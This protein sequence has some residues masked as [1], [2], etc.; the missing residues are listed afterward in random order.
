T[1][2]KVFVAQYLSLHHNNPNDPNDQV[3]LAAGSVFMAVTITDGDGDTASAGGNDISQQVGFKD[4]GP[5]ITAATNTGA[6]VAHDETPGVQ[7][8]DANGT[9]TAYGAAT[10][11]SLFTAVPSPGDDPDVTG[12]GPIGYA[13]STAS[14]VTV[15]NANYGADGQGAAPLSYALSVTD[16]TDS[17]VA[18]TAGTEIYLYNG[19]GGLVLGRVGTWS[20]ADPNGTTAFALADDPT[21]GKVFVAQ[22]LS[23]HHPNAADPNDQVNLAAGSVFMA[24][25]ITDGDGDTASAGGNDISLQVG[26]KDDGPAIT[27]ATNTGASVVHDETPGVQA[28]DANGTDTAYGAATIASLFTAV[29]SPGDDPDVTGSGPIGYAAS[30][31]SLVTVTNANYG[32]DG[33]GAAPLSYALSVTDGT[34][35]GV[36]TT[37]GTEI[38]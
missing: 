34:D 3:N 30:T 6:S 13:A 29:P 18:T 27:A 2:G 12:S 14:L 16:G 5:A 24:V 23:L 25:T 15:T 8:G 21:S 9:D 38:Y 33:Q 36:A 32:A 4:D 20:A 7:A 26:F 17:G 10:I 31:A 37:A 35:S 28:G 11:A 19:P 22:Y 1:S